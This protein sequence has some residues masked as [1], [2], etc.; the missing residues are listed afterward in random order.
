MRKSGKRVPQFR[1]HG[2]TK[3]T[4]HSTVSRKRLVFIGTVRR[5]KGFSVREI[6]DRLLREE[7]PQRRLTVDYPRS[8]ESAAQDQS[9]VFPEDADDDQR[10]VDAAIDCDA[11]GYPRRNAERIC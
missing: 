9:L 11:I 3:T 7:T 6:Q 5:R 4:V 8:E 10:W 1:V 2:G